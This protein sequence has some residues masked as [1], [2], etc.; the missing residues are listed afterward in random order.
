MAHHHDHHPDH[1][2]DHGHH[3]GHAHAAPRDGWRFGLGMALNLVFVV[4]VAAIGVAINGATAVLFMAG[5][6]GDINV[7]G[8]FLH[9]VGDAAVSAGVIVAGA[10]IAVT[11]RAWIDPAASLVIVAVIG[12]STWG[13]LKEATNMA[14]DVAPDHV[15]VEA[16]RGLLQ[17]L[18]GVAEVHDLHVWNVS[19]TETAMTAHLVAPGG[20]DE[21]RLP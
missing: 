12:L 8:A 4:V 7:R 13:L 2:H 17:D 10:A 11:G 1:H 5:R 14:M 15:D 21:G 20:G 19:T 18:P 3:H 16:V 9:M 6:K